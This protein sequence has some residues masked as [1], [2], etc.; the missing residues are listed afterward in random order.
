MS[1]EV[2]IAKYKEQVNKIILSY[3]LCENCATHAKQHYQDM[4]ND[5][6]DPEHAAII[7]GYALEDDPDCYHSMFQNNQAPA[8]Q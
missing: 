4:V 5:M 8:F 6:I 3:G 7:I 1:R 2:E